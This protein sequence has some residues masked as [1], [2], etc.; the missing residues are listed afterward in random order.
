MDG[1]TYLFGVVEVPLAYEDDAS[2]TWGCWI[3][4]DRS[5]HDAY[6]EAFQSPAADRLTGDG[7]LAN[8]IPGYE[9]A[10]DVYKRQALP[11]AH[12]HHGRRSVRVRRRP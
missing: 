4:V 5:L 9:D 10:A 6:L 2:F 12:G 3:E 8:D 11:A 7:R 1:R